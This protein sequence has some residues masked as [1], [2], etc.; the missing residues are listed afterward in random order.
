[1]LGSDAQTR[2]DAL[3]DAVGELA[4]AADDADGF[5]AAFAALRQIG[6][7][8]DLSEVLNALHVPDDAGERAEALRRMLLRIPD[9]WGRW[10]GCS[11]GWYPILVELD[12]Q[13]CSLFPQYEL[14]QV[15]EKYGGLRFYWG[16]G[17][18]I[19]DPADPEP[20]VPGLS[21][22]ATE[23]D[24]DAAWSAWGAAHDAWSQRLAHYLET[25]EGASRQESF[26]RRL[27]LAE[28]LVET[29][30]R[31]ASITCELC[32]VP[33][34]SCCTPGPSPWYQTLCA[35]CARQRGYI[36]TNQRDAS[37]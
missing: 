34:E 22:Q 28:Q 15:K 14:H 27:R 30:E 19:T 6:Q 26:D 13:L 3:K 5:A 10:I 35:G 18:P 8:V 7:G 29:A 24:K 12:E 20:D 21:E 11:R 1:M 2:W 25:E 4:G 33:G 9:G 32:G 17:E 16:E 36:P 31:R 23:A 37:S